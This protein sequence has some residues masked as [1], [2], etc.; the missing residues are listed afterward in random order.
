MALLEIVTEEVND[1]EKINLLKQF[2]DENLGKGVI[3]CNDTPGFIGNR[4][5]VMQCKLL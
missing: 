4:I 5:G 2:C 1:I 3:I